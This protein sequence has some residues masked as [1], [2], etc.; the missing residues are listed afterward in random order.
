MSVALTT[1][2]SYP[3]AEKARA[4]LT[5]RGQVVRCPE[6][7][8][9]IFCCATARAD[10]AGQ[11]RLE[12]RRGNPPRCAGRPRPRW[13]ADAWPGAIRRALRTRRYVDRAPPRRRRPQPIR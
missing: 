11:G 3:A 10:R 5:I 7:T 8:T 2:T 12:D 6:V 1:R 9:Q 13:P 4:A